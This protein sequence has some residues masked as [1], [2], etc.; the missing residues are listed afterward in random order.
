MQKIILTVTFLLISKM[1]KDCL[2][3]TDNY[4][5][6]VKYHNLHNLV[7]ISSCSWYEFYTEILKHIN[8]QYTSAQF[9]W[10]LVWIQ[11]MH[12]TKHAAI[13]T[14][15]CKCHLP[16]KASPPPYWL[17][18]QIMWLSKQSTVFT[19][20]FPW[21][22]VTHHRKVIN[23]NSHSSNSVDILV[24]LLTTHIT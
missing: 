7:T 15:V 6:F 23:V 10:V 5:L 16:I 1:L 13:M 4:T 3:F 17:I 19:S 24:S 18:D 22:L 8:E 21:E 2:S 14:E 20:I 12:Q 9:K 11:L